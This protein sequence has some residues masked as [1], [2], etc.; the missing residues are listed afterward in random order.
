MA[1]DIQKLIFEMQNRPEDFYF[2][3]ECRFAHR[4]SGQHIWI[5]NGRAF[6]KLYAPY[7]IKFTFADRWRFHRAFK[8]FKRARRQGEREWLRFWLC[9]PTKAPIK[10]VVN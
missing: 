3:S 2:P 5:A 4:P 10:V 9:E 6:Y 8:R 1:S 7:E